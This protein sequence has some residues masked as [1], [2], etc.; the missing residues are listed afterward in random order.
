MKHK[1]ILL[2]ILQLGFFYTNISFAQNETLTNKQKI[3]VQKIVHDYLLDNPKI[4]LEVAEK[5]KMIEQK[6]RAEK[7]QQSILKNQQELFSSTSPTIGDQKAQITIVE[8]FDYNCGHC[9]SMTVPIHNIITKNKDIRIIFKEFPVLGASSMYAAKAA[10][11]SR[12]Q[13]KY[14][15]F[16]KELMSHHG[17]LTEKSILNTA[18]KVGLDI[19]K[20]KNDMKSPVFNTQLNEIKKLANKIGIR[21]TPAFIIAKQPNSG[22]MR[23]R[24]IPGAISQEGLLKYID[25]L[26]KNEKQ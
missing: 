4:L 16:H 1:F 23:V 19:E 26:R 20:L 18:I 5:L 9:K 22:N 6:T 25:A 2:F 17:K 11:A 14:H 3:E 7:T 15:E 12:S 13:G 21:G 24:F 8:F 10:L